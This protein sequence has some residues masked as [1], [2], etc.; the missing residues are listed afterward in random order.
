[1]NSCV[2]AGAML[3]GRLWKSPLLFRRTFP[4]LARGAKKEQLYCLPDLVEAEVAFF[5]VGFKFSLDF[6]A[7]VGSQIGEFFAIEVVYIA[8]ADLL[9]LTGEDVP[10]VEEGVAGVEVRVSEVDFAPGEDAFFP[11]RAVHELP[12]GVDE[13]AAGGEQAAKSV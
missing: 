10:P 5:A 8:Q 4:P 6:K 13:E 9:H 12:F 3:V 7:A 2:I 1:M 11:A